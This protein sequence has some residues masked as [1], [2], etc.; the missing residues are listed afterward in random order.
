MAHGTRDRAAG[1]PVID[2]FELPQE[3][4]PHNEGHTVAAWVAMAGIMLGFGIGALGLALTTTWLIVVGVAVIVIAL[5]AG[6]VLRRLGYGQP[7]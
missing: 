7:R 2:N 3:L 4:P 1:I 6:A 5:V